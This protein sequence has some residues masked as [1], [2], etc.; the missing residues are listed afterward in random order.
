MAPESPPAI[1]VEPTPEFR[2]LSCPDCGHQVARSAASCPNCGSDEPGFVAK[3][4]PCRKCQGPMRAIRR[5]P[6]PRFH[7][8][9]VGPV[10]GGLALVAWG[11]NSPLLFGANLLGLGIVAIAVGNAASA[12]LQDSRRDLLLACAKC[13]DPRQVVSPH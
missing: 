8:M 13:K 11:L 7:A 12:Q 5:E 6:R 1:P 2:L 10:A 4:E 9:W 3:Q